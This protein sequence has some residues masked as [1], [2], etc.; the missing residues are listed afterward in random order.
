MTPVDKNAIV[1]MLVRCV[2]KSLKEF[3]PTSGRLSEPMIFIDAARFLQALE[4]ERDEIVT[5]EPDGIALSR[6]EALKRL[7]QYP[8]SIR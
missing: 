6:Y 5:D 1:D 3:V 8:D 2:N 7:S 4:A